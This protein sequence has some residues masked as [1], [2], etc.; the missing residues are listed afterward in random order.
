MLEEFALTF[1]N[2]TFTKLIKGF[3]T[4]TNLISN[5]CFVIGNQIKSPSFGLPSTLSVSRSST[6]SLNFSREKI[7]VVL[8][9]MRIPN[10]LSNS[11]CPSHPS[12]LL[13][14][15]LIALALENLPSESSSK[16]VSRL[17]IS[18]GT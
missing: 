18:L 14:Y 7:N 3:S 5:K 11:P 15:A 4:S 8:S 1:P 13:T 10:L 6:F 2:I 9:S 17:T 12:A 16:I